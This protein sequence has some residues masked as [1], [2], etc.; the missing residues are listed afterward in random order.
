MD[1][2]APVGTSIKAAQGGKVTFS[3]WKNGYGKVVIV[4]HGNG[5]STYYAHANTLKVKKGRL[6]KEKSSYS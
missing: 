5:Y 1:I 6:C 3:G 4:N 2:A